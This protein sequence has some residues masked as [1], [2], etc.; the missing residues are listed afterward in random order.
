MAIRTRGGALQIDVQVTV[1]GKTKRHRE[2]HTGDMASAKARESS[3]KAALLNGADPGGASTRGHLSGDSGLTLRKALDHLMDVRWKTGDNVRQNTSAIKLAC[4][5]FG[6]DLPLGDLTTDKVDAYIS[7]MMR[8]GLK[9]STIGSRLN[10]LSVACN[11][12][13]RRGKIRAVPVFEKPSAKGN[14][15]TRLLTDE[16]RAAIVRHMEEDYDLVPGHCKAGTPTGRD[17]ADLYIMLQDT[18]VRPSELRRCRHQDLRGDILAVLFTKTENPRHLPLTQRAL[19]AWQRQAVRHPDETPFAWA[20]ENRI[21]NGWAWIRE[22][23]CKP[24]ATDPEFVTYLMRHDCATRLY[25]LTRD[26][27][28][29]RDWMG[30][31]DVSM[32]LR[33]A[34]L[35]PTEL[36][37]ARDMLNGDAATRLQVAA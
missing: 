22:V 29:V 33:Y 32:T 36:E 30:H 14:E 15:R 27:M 3:I 37:R 24:K 11:H 25:A 16:E 20:D 17:Y 7:H 31:T 19:E 18:G 28:L 23:M 34:K 6:E 13:H 35:F 9:P 10:V 5:F 12:Y 4:A 21:K 26:L 2:K 8:E 1:K